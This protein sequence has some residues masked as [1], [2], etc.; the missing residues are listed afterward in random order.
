MLLGACGAVPP[1][2]L[3]VS[4]YPPDMRAR[5]ALFA[6]KCSRCHPL[7]RPLHARVGQHGW[8][9]YVRRMSRHPGAGISEPEQREIAQ[10]LQYYARR[11]A[12]KQ[13]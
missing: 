7:D 9:D 2:T 8:A 1:N 6:R 11:E 10:F 5:Y 12:E 3:D 13:Q 4:G